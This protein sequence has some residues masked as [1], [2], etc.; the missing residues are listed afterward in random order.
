MPKVPSIPKNLNFVVELPPRRNDTAVVEKNWKADLPDGLDFDGQKFFFSDGLDVRAKIQWMEESLL[1]VRLSV[2]TKLKGECSRCL[3]DAELAISDDLMYLYYLRGLEVGKDTRLES[4]DGFMPVEVDFWGRTLCLSDQVWET[5][6]MLLPV[7]MLC[8]EDCAGL[9]P[10]CGCDLNDIT[11]SCKAP[12]TDPRFDALRGVFPTGDDVLL[13]KPAVRR[14]A[15]K[16][17]I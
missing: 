10:N 1:S 13:R 7:K 2:V 4:D 6:L 11:C 16:R 9:C 14:E 15:A 17:I 5:L 3:G 12:V 8:K